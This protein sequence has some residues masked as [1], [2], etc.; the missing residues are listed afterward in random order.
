MSWIV[1]KLVWFVSM[2]LILVACDDPGESIDEKEE[3]IEKLES[4]V[5]ELEE[6]M[7]KIDS[8]LVEVK[9]ALLGL[10][11]EI[12]DFS[13]EN[14]RLNVP[15]VEYHFEILREAFAKLEEVP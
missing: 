8:E 4:Q 1:K 6:K 13:R 10:A 12:E 9:G 5:E 7:E 2:S 15:D 3:E 14:W 11:N